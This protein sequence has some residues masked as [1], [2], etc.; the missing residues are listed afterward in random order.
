MNPAYTLS[1]S[2]APSEA[3]PPPPYP[4]T[5]KVKSVHEYDYIT[6]K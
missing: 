3:P 1:N 2:T 4:G 6:Q 5:S